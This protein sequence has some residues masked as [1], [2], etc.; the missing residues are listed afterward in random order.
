MQ[1]GYHTI[2]LMHHNILDAIDLIA[3][4]GYRS[5]GIAVD[6][7]CLSP[8]DRAAKVQLQ[9]IK[10]R[11]RS[12]N[13]TSCIEA[14][15]RFLLDP[16]QAFLPGL[17]E[18]DRKKSES[19]AEFLKHCIDLAEELDSYC[20]SISSGPCPQTMTFNAAIDQLVSQLSPLLAYADQRNVEI[21]LEPEPDMLIDSLGRFDRLF[22]LLPHRRINLTLN[23]AHMFCAAEV[24]VG[25]F[26]DQWGEK[27]INVHVSDALAGSHEHL[28]FGSGQI[29]FPP[30]LESLGRAGY[31]NGIQVE[32]EDYSPNGVATLQSAYRFL[33][34]LI[35]ETQSQTG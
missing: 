32:L 18:P 33:A 3:D 13:L 30:I 17:V 12:M 10:H 8:F 15:P 21:G 5:I 26:I 22:H 1:L 7:H 24:P 25:G 20:V 23:V 4:T 35:A 6:H 31:K 11:L 27:I 34:P 19:R 28:L 9:K 29:F 14:N 16:S 2:G